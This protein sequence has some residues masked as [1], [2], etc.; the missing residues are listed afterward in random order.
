[1][2]K[3]EEKYH[4]K[5]VFVG[6]IKQGDDERQIMEYLDE[7]EFLAETAGAVGNR[8]FIQKVDKPDNRTYIRS[9]KLQEIK[10]YITENEI[11]VV[12]FDDELSPTQ[13]RNI[14]KELNVRILDRTN[15][16]LDIFAQRAKTAYAKMQVELAQYQYLLPRLTRMWTHLERQ[17]GG[18]GMRGPGETQIETDRRIIQDKISKLKEQLK[19]VDKQM[20]S[21]RGNRA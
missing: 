2:A 7:L 17:K 6:V 11:D 12:I 4:E 9:G 8:K 13:L 16:I 14:E 19:K 1:M 5:A 20:A 21:Q 10:D 3:I 18:I 15:L